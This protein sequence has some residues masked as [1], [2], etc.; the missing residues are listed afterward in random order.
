MKRLQW[1]LLAVCLAV[2]PVL[3]SCDDSDGYSL[4]DFTPPLW[5][6]VRVTGNAF[7]LDSDVWGTL[8]PVN[9]NM[10]WYNP[11]DGQRVITV[12]N[13]LWDDF[14]GFDHAV[15]LLSLRN[16]LTKEVETLTPENTEEFGNDPVLIYKGDIGISGGYM[17]IVFRQNL[18]LRTKHRISL[19][20]PQDDVS[21]YDEEGYMKLELRYNNYDD[22][23]G[24]RAYSAV[25][26]NLNKL[27]LTSDIKGIKLTLNSEVNGDVE[28]TFNF[29]QADDSSLQSL[30]EID[31]SEMQL[32]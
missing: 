8:W 6:T 21:L 1:L 15:K 19:V 28:V 18:P 23:T 16:V 7:Y 11:V 10:G 26:F 30:T 24:R 20:R 17:N 31:I 32:E 5:A 2:M 13:P 22:L 14:Q 29:R 3:Q 9:T 27:D 25:S 4:G 12:F